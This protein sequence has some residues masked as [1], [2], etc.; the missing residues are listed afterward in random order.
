MSKI[1]TSSPEVQT[2]PFRL[3]NDPVAKFDA[4]FRFDG[5]RAILDCVMSATRNGAC[6]PSTIE[7]ALTIADALLAP[8]VDIVEFGEKEVKRRHRERQIEAY[9][10]GAELGKR[11]K[12][13]DRTAKAFSKKPAVR[14]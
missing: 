3:E 14:K 2:A 7:D 10:A 9:E 1:A 12:A 11:L 5:A 6:D 13:G 4:G 8:L